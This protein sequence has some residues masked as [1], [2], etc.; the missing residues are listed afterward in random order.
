MLILQ[1][2]LPKE[3]QE[4]VIHEELKA[5]S[6]WMADKGGPLVRHEQAL[7]KTYIEWKLSNPYGT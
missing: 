6:S 7:L 2:T 5:F 1:S 3:K 4:E